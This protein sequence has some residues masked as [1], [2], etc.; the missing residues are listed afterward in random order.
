MKKKG[1]T[2]LEMVVVL[3][4]IGII[5]TI[6]IPTFGPIIGKLKLTTAAENLANTLES[7]KQ[8]AAT[9]GVDCYV[10]FP[11]TTNTDMDYRSYK[12]YSYNGTN[13]TTI[14][15]WENLPSGLSIDPNSTFL[16]SGLNNGTLSVPFPEDID[17]GN[18]R[19]IRYV[20]FVPGGRA[21]VRA[22]VKILDNQTNIFNVV[23]FYDRPGRI[24]VWDTGEQ[25]LDE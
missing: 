19:Q 3:F 2:L 17:R 23:T 4:I 8:Y 21:A 9:S 18:V 20:Q 11:T 6:T 5:L 22:S 25:P 15:K 16:T 13:G 1:F 7:A 24:K 14:G 10:L 12:I